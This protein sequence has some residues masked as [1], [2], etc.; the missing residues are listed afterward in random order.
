MTA[1]QTM[2]DYTAA[3]VAQ[4]RS[5]A[6]FTVQTNKDGSHAIL[7]N[8]VVLYSK[9]I[10]VAPGS[11]SGGGTPTDANPR[12]DRVMIFDPSSPTGTYADA[13][14]FVNSLK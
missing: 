4:S 6:V 1:R 5:G 7:R 14:I 10:Y 2:V 9:V 12:G 8:G 11:G 13:Q 3:V